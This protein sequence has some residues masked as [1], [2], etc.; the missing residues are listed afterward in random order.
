MGWTKLAHKLYDVRGGR[1]AVCLAQLQHMSMVGDEIDVQ[2]QS[3]LSWTRRSYQ[4][5]GVVNKVAL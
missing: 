2:I 3:L 5:V 4:A 1:L